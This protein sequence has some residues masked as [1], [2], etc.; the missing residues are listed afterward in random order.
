VV[1]DYFGVK[2]TGK[3][4]DK[5][6]LW[7]LSHAERIPNKDEKFVIDGLAVTV[8]KASERHIRRVIISQP[9]ENESK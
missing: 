3:P 7:V 4:T 1:E 5:V 9:K 8:A 2:L 6:S